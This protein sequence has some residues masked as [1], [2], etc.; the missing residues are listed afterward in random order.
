MWPQV[1]EELTTTIL[2]QIHQCVR[3]SGI[4]VRIH[5][6]RM[7]L[8]NCSRSVKQTQQP[9]TDFDAAQIA[10]SIKERISMMTDDDGFPNQKPKTQLPTFADFMN[11]EA[12]K[13]ELVL[14]QLE[15]KMNRSDSSATA[16]HVVNLIGWLR[17]MT[18]ESRKDVKEIIKSDSE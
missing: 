18:A 6:L 9:M 17:Q 4:T 8:V 14:N 7:F 10:L 3:A 15:L 16:A 12:D 1:A 2:I 13:L 11:A 5:Y